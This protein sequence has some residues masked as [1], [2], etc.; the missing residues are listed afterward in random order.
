MQE[1]LITKSA[2]TLGPPVGIDIEGV[3]ASSSW[4][5][6]AGVSGDYS[7]TLNFTGNVVDYVRIPYGGTPFPT[8]ENVEIRIR[9]VIYSVY[10]ASKPFY[11][12]SKYTGATAS[13]NTADWVLQ[14]NTSGILMFN[15][16]ANGVNPVGT[17]TAIPL[18]EEFEITWTRRDNTF[19]IHFNGILVYTGSNA[20]RQSPI[21]WMIGSYLNQGQTGATINGSRAL[22]SLLGLRIRRPR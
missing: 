14:R 7:G 19:T 8:G 10:E 6:T 20:A 22:W 4:T 21:D 12:I 18:N 3:A 1:A 2:A 16:G 17:G 15:V 13:V 9:A 5:R 11:L